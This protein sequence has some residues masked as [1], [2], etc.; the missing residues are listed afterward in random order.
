[1]WQAHHLGWKRTWSTPVKI[2][3]D[4]SCSLTRSCIIVLGE[5]ARAIKQETQW[6]G[7]KSEKKWDYPHFQKICNDE[8]LLWLVWGHSEFCQGPFLHLLRWAYEFYLDVHLSNL[9]HLYIT[10][11]PQRFIRKLLEILINVNKAI[12]YKINLQKSIYAF[13]YTYNKKNLP[14]HL[15]FLILSWFQSSSGTGTM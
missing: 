9:L 3:S 8:I 10:D 11:R 13:L 6:M 1:M 2:K 4:T 5:L 14:P 7:F 12:K 15:R